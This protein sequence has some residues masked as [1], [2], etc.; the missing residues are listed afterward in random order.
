[1]EYSDAEN[2]RWWAGMNRIDQQVL[3]EKVLAV[4]VMI[5]AR[6]AAQR[7]RQSC[8]DRKLPQAA[9]LSLLRKWDRFDRNWEAASND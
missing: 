5:K 2:Y 1:M 7:V 6:V 3:I 9:D 4:A 8:V